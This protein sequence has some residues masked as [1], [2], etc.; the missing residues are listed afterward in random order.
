MEKKKDLW[1][2]GHRISPI[3][4]SGNYD[5]VI[6]ETAPNVPGPPPHYHTKLHEL[7]L[8]VEGEMDFVIDGEPKTLRQ[9][10]SV[11]LPANVVHTFTNTG[12]TT[13]R[14]V[15]V[16]SPKGF[17]SFFEDMGV[18]ESEAG[19][20]TKSVDERIINR[21]MKEAANYDMHIKI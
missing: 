14:W 13:C 10:E 20:M 12:S 1:V 3:A 18:P 5:M 11:D 21:V 19:A 8:V 6:G 17:L 2:I 4:V 15:N 16:H 7:F 9:G